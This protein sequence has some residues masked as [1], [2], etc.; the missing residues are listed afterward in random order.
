MRLI[1][2]AVA[3]SL[4]AACTISFVCAQKPEGPSSPAISAA[5]LR[6]QV[7]T[8]ASD[9]MEGRATGTPKAMEAARYL[10]SELA[11]MG[12]EPGGEDGTWFQKVPMGSTEYLEIPQLECVGTDGAKIAAVGGVDFELTDGGC[13]RREL[14]VVIAA[15]AAEIPKQADAKAALVL[16]SDKSKDRSQWLE[17]AGVPGG[18]GWGLLIGLGSDKPGISPMDEPPRSRS[19]LPGP[20]PRITVRGKL[21]QAF[22]ERKI[23]RLSYEAPILSNVLEAVNVIG[24]ISGVGT[25]SNKAIAAEVIEFSAHYDHLPPVKNAEAGQDRI[26]NGA[27][28]DASGCAVV[29]ELAEAFAHGSKPARTLL[30]FFATGEEIGLVGS[31]YSLD[32]PLVPL[33]KIVLDLNFEMLGRPDPEVV[34]PARMWLTGFERS[35]LG[36]ALQRAEAP[37]VPDMRPK[38]GF[39]QRSDNYAMALKGIVAQ[40]LSSFG[41]HGDYHKV[42]DEPSTL[43]YAHMEACALGAFAGS[44]SMVD[45]T[46]RPTWRKGMDPS[47][48]EEKPAPGEVPRGS[49]EGPLKKPGGG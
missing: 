23:A 48:P 47:K 32:H 33:D 43:D 19:R 21:R 1:A 9:A 5:D 25:T 45:G 31:S 36:E 7:E 38:Q 37:V 28:D 26:Y 20:A 11:R 44:R 24:K 34:A 10:A 41:L 12:L 39:F 42:S 35:D 18:A 15:S 40:T 6:R 4:L 30:F 2:C 22:V 8:L 16:L 3:S 17:T 14:A 27:D 29:L 46:F 49:P 13:E